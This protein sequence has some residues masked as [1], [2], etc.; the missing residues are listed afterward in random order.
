MSVCLESI[1]PNLNILFIALNAYAELYTHNGEV[2][3]FKNSNINSFYTIA[4]ASPQI[5]D[6]WRNDPEWIVGGGFHF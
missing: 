6:L 1:F 4:F 3:V 2:F 5:T